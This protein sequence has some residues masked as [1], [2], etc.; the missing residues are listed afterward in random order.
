MKPSEHMG[1]YQRIDEV[2]DRYRLYQYAE[3]FDG[4]DVYGEFLNVVIYPRVD[5]KRVR[6][7]AERHGRRWEQHVNRAHHALAT[8]DIVESYSEGLVNEFSMTTA[9]RYWSRI[10][11]FYRWL[12]WNAEYPH[13][14]SPVLMAA[15]E[16]GASADIWRSR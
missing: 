5:T 4:R 16:D 8:P 13:V 15:D 14:Y 1:V 10:E 2:P 3:A 9:W 11:K 7:N 12:M 6:S